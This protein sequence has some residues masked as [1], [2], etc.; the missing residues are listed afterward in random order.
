MG[1]ADELV[2]NNTRYAAEYT[3]DRPLPPR[4]QL[5]VVACMDSRLDVFALLGLEVG[6]A[7]IMRNAGGV[8]TDDMIRSLVI[9]QRKLGTREII[10]IHHTDCGALTFT[11]DELRNDLLDE[12]GIKPAWSPESFTDLDVDLRQSMERLRRDPFLVD[13]TQVRGFVFDV[14][15]GKLREVV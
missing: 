14:H 11:D 7:H 13:S 8:I 9:S 1:I 3:P 4:R 2:E 5:A 6:D 10:L 15:T 12:T